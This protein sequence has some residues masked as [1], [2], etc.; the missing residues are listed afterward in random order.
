M[1]PE[2]WK[3]LNELM[4][5]APSGSVTTQDTSPAVNPSVVYPPPTTS[6]LPKSPGNITPYQLY[7]FDTSVLSNK[8]DPK[9]SPVELPKDETKAFTSGP[10]GWYGPKVEVLP[11]FEGPSVLTPW[12]KDF[13]EFA[14]RAPS[15]DELWQLEAEG[16]LFDPDTNR[17]LLPLTNEFLVPYRQGKARQNVLGAY[18]AVVETSSG[19]VASTL[20]NIGVNDP[21]IKS[22]DVFKKREQLRDEGYSFLEASRLAW[23]Q[24]DMPSARLHLIWGYDFDK[25]EFVKHDIP[26]WGD[27]TFGGI[28]VGTKGFMENV[29]DPTLLAGIG[30]KALGVT[31][32]I[33]GAS[34]RTA[35]NIARKNTL[36]AIINPAVVKGLT[37]AELDMWIRGNR[38]FT[39]NRPKDPQHQIYIGKYD[40]VGL[41][42]KKSLDNLANAGLVRKTSDYTYE[43][44]VTP[45]SK[46]GSEFVARLRNGI[47]KN[48]EVNGNIRVSAL[49]EMEPVVDEIVEIENGFIKGVAE[50]LGINPSAAASSRVAKALVGYARQVISADELVELTLISNLDTLGSRFQVPFVGKQLPV[51]I[52][53]Q[54]FV[55]GTGKLW[56][57]VFSIPS[58]YADNLSESARRYIDRYNEIVEEMD[59]LRESSGLRMLGKSLEDGWYYVPR[60]VRDI[61]GFT[62]KRPSSA[63]MQRIFD[64]ATEGFNS[65]IRYEVDPR[66]TLHTHMRSTYRDIIDKQLTDFIE[67]SSVGVSKLVP[68]NIQIAMQA[69]ARKRIAAER[70]L[71]KLQ[72][73]MRVLQVGKTTPPVGT[74]VRAAEKTIRAA[75]QAERAALQKEIAN[76]DDLFKIAMKEY[77]TNKGIYQRAKKNAAKQPAA[78]GSLFGRVDD[79]DIAIGQWRSRFFA[80]EDV[81]L[82]EKA[83]GTLGYKRDDLGAFTRNFTKL[84]NT[85]R[86]LASVGDFAAPFIQGLPLLAT[87]PEKWGKAAT[88]HYAAFFDPTVQA[89]FVSKNLDT[90]REMARYGV[91]VGD[92]EFFAALKAGEGFT[93]GKLVEKLPKGASL[94]K[95]S[96]ETQRQTFGRFQSSYNVFLAMNRAYLWDGMKTSF[97]N[98]GGTR[99]ELAA[100]VRNL[101]GALDSRALGVGP[102][103]RAGESVWLAFSPKLLRST[104]AVVSDAVRATRRETLALP[105]RVPVVRKV[106]RYEAKRATVQQRESLKLLTRMIAG[107][108]GIY[109]SAGLAMGKSERE[110]SQGLNPLSGGKF[111][112]YEIN[113]QWIGVGGQYRALLQ[114]ATELTS[115]LA[116][117]GEDINVLASRNILENPIAKGISY[118][119]APGLGIAGAVVEGVTQQK[120]DVLPFDDIDSLADV[121]LHIGKSSLPFVLQGILEGDN[122]ESAIFGGFGLRTRALS[123][124][125]DV[126]LLRQEQLDLRGIDLEWTDEN[127]DLRIKQEID[128]LPPV[129]EALEER[130]V[131]YEERQSE[132]QAVKEE[133]ERI[134]DDFKQKVEARFENLGPGKEF[135]GTLKTLYAE[136]SGG[137]DTVRESDRYKE[138]TEF[139]EEKDSARY[140]FNKALEDYTAALYDEELEDEILGT[141][142][143]D[144]RSRRLENLRDQYGPTRIEDIAEY[145]KRHAPAPIRR[146]EFDMD[147]MR[148][149]FEIGRNTASKFGYEKIWDRYM[150]IEARDRD[151]FARHNA[152]IRF[153]KEEIEQEK[154]RFLKQNLPAA[155]KLWMWGYL[156]SD[157]P[158]NSE[159][160]IYIDILIN[161]QGSDYGIVTDRM[162]IEQFLPAEAVFTE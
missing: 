129:K 104:I 11:G 105:T 157:D 31:S 153:L 117:G 42:Q 64:E 32:K 74:G 115:A 51:K 70:N 98:N 67:P 35:I 154:T 156:T 118:R 23:Q 84:A 45:T 112:S 26:L 150:A 44:V 37:E 71:R 83:L 15:T 145:L 123:P 54:G 55:E 113:G 110:I 5:M 6:P 130:N 95:V 10:M 73:R 78:P 8:P 88:M 137:L 102:K 7:G 149:Y 155:A 69:A 100:Y 36:D 121:P 22:G 86:F 29:A 101:T 89:R 63:K 38:L 14:H 77:D 92:N 124:A 53:A 68:E 143:Y 134:N 16:R 12:A 13:P 139:F 140:G 61:N 59:I 148:P 56:N 75:R 18:Q 20:G 24:T 133:Q 19:V 116:P 80:A 4:G 106:A 27:S 109:V 135:R 46:E 2:D 58:Q 21:M 146:Y 50:K 99:A 114:F 159:L 122:T 125:D 66:A 161:Q 41:E 151:K 49:R 82:L 90:F 65:G 147:F 52:D 126:R 132:Y 96:R 158:I 40:N 162:Q 25:N 81:E 3:K 142:N 85:T 28:D 39:I 136:R 111:L 160:D 87:N 91:P 138:A 60:Q 47:S 97:L 152:D 30:G 1:S 127:L 57:D 120:V 128:E 72:N 141:Y 94:R 119:G 62:L 144:E 17:P 79:A 93:P 48:P 43:Y 9:P 33:A 103:Q 108:G 107:I 76:A 131:M 34:A